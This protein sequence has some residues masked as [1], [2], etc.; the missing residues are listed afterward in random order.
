MGDF[1]FSAMWRKQEHVVQWDAN[2]GGTPSEES[3]TVYHGEEL[4]ELPTSEREGYHLLGWTTEPDGSE[5]VHEDTVIT[6]SRTFHAKWG[7]N[8]SLTVTYR[9]NKP[10]TITYKTNF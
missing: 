7:E 3:R 5:F 10:V 8:A 6:S 1:A 9:D 2:G 4:G